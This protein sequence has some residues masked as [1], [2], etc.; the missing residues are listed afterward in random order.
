MKSVFKIQNSTVQYYFHDRFEDVT[1][2]INSTDY[3]TIY[4]IEN[5]KT[6]YRKDDAVLIDDK[7]YV[8]REVANDIK[9]NTITYLLRT[10]AEYTHE[11]LESKVKAYQEKSNHFQ[12]RYNKIKREL[13]EIKSKNFT[14]FIKKIF[15]KLQ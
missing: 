5:L 4:E 9:N 10:N 12:K 7:L 6:Q 14:I 2:V 13:D 1:S 8:V 15:K 11:D 3:V